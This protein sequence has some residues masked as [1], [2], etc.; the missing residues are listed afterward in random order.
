MVLRS[1]CLEHGSRLSLTNDLN[2]QN[3]IL[4]T[5]LAQLA[6]AQEENSKIYFQWNN[7]QLLWF[8]TGSQNEAFCLRV[9][10][11]KFKGPSSTLNTT[12]N[13]LISKLHPVHLHHISIRCS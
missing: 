2:I 11:S 8:Q 10:T 1:S 13:Q 7:L 12:L 9:Q 5:E 3:T 4:Q 6:S